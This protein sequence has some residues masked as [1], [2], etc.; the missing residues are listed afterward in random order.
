M[1][2]AAETAR[3]L[4]GEPVR[5]AMRRAADLQV[6]LAETPDRTPEEVQRSEELDVRLREATTGLRTAFDLWAAEPLGLDGARHALETSVSKIV[7]SSG[8]LADEVSDKVERAESLA[9]RYRF[10]HWP[11]EFP[12]VFHRERPGFDVVVGNPPWN[13][14]TDRGARILRAAGTWTAWTAESG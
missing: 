9:G 10:F 6:R 11:L 1:W 4:T 12:G 8:R 3:L 2:S 7:E 14:I 13:E 5:V